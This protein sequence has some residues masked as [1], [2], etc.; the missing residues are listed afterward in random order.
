[1]KA[2]MRKRFVPAHYYRELKMQSMRQ[3]TKSEERSSPRWESQRSY[4]TRM[5][6]ES[7]QK[8]KREKSKTEQQFKTKR[9]ECPSKQ[10]VNLWSNIEDDSTKEKKII[11][12]SPPQRNDN[13]EIPMEKNVLDIVESIGVKIEGMQDDIVELQPKEDEKCITAPPLE[14]EM[15]GSDSRTNPFE[16]VENDMI[17]PCIEVNADLSKV[18]TLSVNVEDEF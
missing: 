2:V 13:I 16:E 1:M 3:V 12:V 7:L 6:R 9:G 4:P 5:V 10:F 17:Q 11:Y 18:Q 15:E 8:P 14:E